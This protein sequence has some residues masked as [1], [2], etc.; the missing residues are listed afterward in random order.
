[1]SGLQN[2]SHRNDQFV[3]SGNGLPRLYDQS[4]ADDVY[5]PKKVASAIGVSES[6][7]KRW[8]DSGMVKATKTAGGH[9]RISRS[10]AIAFAN[11]KEYDLRN[12]TA[13]GL[14]DIRKVFI[15]D[16]QDAITQLVNA[17]LDGDE[18][19][20]KRLLVHMFVSGRTVPDLFDRIVSP[21]FAKIG[22]LWKS[23]QVEVYQERVSC[24]MC[25]NA[26]Q[27]VKS[28]I[29]K[30]RAGAPLA[31]GAT[32]QGDHYQLPT[33]GVELCLATH[34]WRAHSLGSNLPIESLERAVEDHFPRVVWVSV[35]HVNEAGTFINQLNDFCRR[36]SLRSTVIVGGNALTPEIRTQLRNA[37]CCDNFAQLILAVQNLNPIR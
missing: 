24:Q 23:G 10:E 37:I 18:Q 14:P 32:L 2:G 3:P 13:I 22:D 11:R 12:P 6:S 31:I 17:M 25:Y 4:D 5:S 19:S 20:C 16:D 27:E 36:V 28:L 33:L 7:L 26:F 15:A 30:P 35:S 29:P 1:M 34:G 21:A 8:C 9:R